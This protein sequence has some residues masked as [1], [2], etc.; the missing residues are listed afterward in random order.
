MKLRSCAALL[1]LVFFVT[2]F[3]QLDITGYYKNDFLMLLPRMGNNLV[4]DVN[5]LRLR[6]DLD[7]TD[8]INLHLEPQYATMIKNQTM[9]LLDV[10]SLDTLD[11]DRTYLKL[12]FPLFDLTGGKQRIA[13]GTGHL[14]NPTDVFNPFT[15]TFAVAED[16]RPGA[17][18]VR[19]KA[20]LW[21]LGYLDAVWLTDNGWQPGIKGVRAKTTLGTYD[22]SASY[23]DLGATSF[24]Y[25]FDTVGDLG[26]FGLR[27]EAAVIYPG[28]ILKY[29]AGWGYTFENG[30]GL[31]MEYY[32]NGAGAAQKKDYVYFAANKLIDE[33]TSALLALYMNADDSSLI[34][35]PAY[36]RNVADNI[37]VILSALISSG[38][39]T[40]ELAGYNLI[41]IRTK[42]S[43]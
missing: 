6:F 25:G 7:I 28:Q 32:F 34:L 26:Q 5:K 23:V 8:R 36:E 10:T 19:I 15:L 24:Q 29:V 42:V 4:G 12:I 13:W 21:A 39:D 43:F 31:D 22:I 11:W 30:L 9:P 35:Y 20:P 16:E 40:G 18:A 17:N 3:A 1:L 33:I 38:P 41:M 2:A 14:F 37:D 27:G